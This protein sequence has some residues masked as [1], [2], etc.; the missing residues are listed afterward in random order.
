MT[1]PEETN[2]EHDGVRRGEAAEGPDSR[3]LL[4]EAL[5]P[6]KEAGEWQRRT[7][8]LPASAQRR[9]LPSVLPRATQL[10]TESQRECP[11]RRS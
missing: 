7:T 8:K 10:I 6:S 5:N 1:E 2:E 9:P 3:A 4:E 11:T